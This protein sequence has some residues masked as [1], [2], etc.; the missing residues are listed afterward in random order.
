MSI[1]GHK[2]EFRLICHIGCG[3]T[4]TSSVQASLKGN[5]DVLT[6]HGFAY[7]GLVL[8]SA[9]V[10]LYSWQRSSASEAILNNPSEEITNQIIEVLDKS[11]VESKARGIDCAI[12]SNEWLVGRHQNII[13]AL[14]AIKQKNVQIDIVVYVRRYDAWAKSAYV[15]WGLKHKTYLGRLR[16]FPRYMKERPLSFARMLEPWADAF[17]DDLTLRNFDCAQDIVED[18]LTAL[19]LPQKI[20]SIRVNEA[21]SLEELLVRALY[22]NFVE[23]QS[24]PADFDRA[25][26][27]RKIDFSL[28]PTQWLR[29]LLPSESDLNKLLEETAEERSAIDELLKKAGQPP[30]ASDVKPIKDV[31]IDP[32]KLSAILMQVLFIQNRK[33]EALKSKLD[34]LS[35]AVEALA[36]K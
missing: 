35:N 29:S 6:S 20:S 14:Q 10:K 25:F 3:K 34:N 21:P 2:K 4:G 30:L 19:N 16:N 27:A 9:P 36:N 28:Q 23:D 5:S 15:Q 12:W 33:L 7:W 18:F 1:Q 13:P 24:T 17:P 8:E 26:Q 11:I 22:N 31:M 32:D